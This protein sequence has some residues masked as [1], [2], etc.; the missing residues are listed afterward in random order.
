M[1]TVI[2]SHFLPVGLLQHFTIT[3]LIEL[4]EVCTKT[5]YFE[6]LSPATISE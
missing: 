6:I 2:I 5:N 1:E 3:S 4:G